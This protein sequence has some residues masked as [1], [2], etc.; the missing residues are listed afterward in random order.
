[1]LLTIDQWRVPERISPR[2]FV[3]PIQAPPGIDHT[4]Q[5]D[6]ACDE[7]P[8]TPTTTRQAEP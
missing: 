2:A 4:V 6:R 8:A 7:V 5:V 3:R 1:L